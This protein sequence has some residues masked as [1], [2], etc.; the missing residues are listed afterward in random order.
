MTESGRDLE[1]SP[2]QQRAKNS[3]SSPASPHFLSLNLFFFLDPTHFEKAT[4]EKL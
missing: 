1:G 4:I 3:L 2:P